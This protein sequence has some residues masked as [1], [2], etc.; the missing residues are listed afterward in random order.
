LLRAGCLH[1]VAGA[2]RGGGGGVRGDNFCGGNAEVTGGGMGRVR[3]G[4]TAGGLLPGF[5]KG[6]R[7]RREVRGM[8][9]RGRGKNGRVLDEKIPQG[10][11]DI[12][13]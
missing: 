1:V 7:R 8:R 6:G 12:I 3:R 10:Y 11:T 2:G 4:M 13:L 9:Q 5:L